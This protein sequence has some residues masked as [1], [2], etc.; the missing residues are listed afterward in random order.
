MKIIHKKINFQDER[1]SIR[2]IFVNDPK[3]HCT[4]IFSREGAVRGNH[5]HRRTTQYTYIVSG[6]ML[7]VSQKFGEKR[8]HKHLLNPG[9]MMVH[10]PEEIHAML[11]QKDTVFLAFASGIRGGR[12]YERD[13]FRV[14]P[15]IEE[16]KK[17]TE[18]FSP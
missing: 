9:D 10:Q 12:D 8:V 7:M 17:D 15:L 2:D 3:D 11:A 5:Y 18:T 4:I 13:T 1:G 14:T 16:K 6:E